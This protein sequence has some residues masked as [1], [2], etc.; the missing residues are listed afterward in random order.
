MVWNFENASDD[1]DARLPGFSRAA[2]AA[3]LRR[4]SERWSEILGEIVFGALVV[5]AVLGMAWP[6]IDRAYPVLEFIGGLG[7]RALLVAGG[8]AIVFA[9]A[10]AVP[11]GLA[12]VLAWL[13]ERTVDNNPG[14]E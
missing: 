7:L 1:R 14:P 9:L 5:A 13:L 2:I 10:W 8:T 11:V 6:W 12:Q 3:D 4:A